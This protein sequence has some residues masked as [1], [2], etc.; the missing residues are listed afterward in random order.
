MLG[1]LYRSVIL[2]K[3]TNGRSGETIL[4][5]DDYEEFRQLCLNYGLSKA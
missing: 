2:K 5:G 4:S 3:L 1:H